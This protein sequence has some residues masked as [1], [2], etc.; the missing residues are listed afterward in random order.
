[1][2]T[3]TEALESPDAAAA[4][5]VGGNELVAN[6]LGEYVQ[7]Q[8][9]KIKGGDSGA[10][11]VIIGLILI[12]IIFQ[13]E[14]SKFLTSGNL[15]NLIQQSGI[16]VMLG[17]AEVYALLLGEIDLSTGFVA[18]IGA[19]ITGELATEP[20]NMNWALA[21]AI[22]LAA[23]AVIGLVQGL[24]ITKLGLPSFVVTLAGYL[25]FN[26]VLLY[27]IQHDKQATGGSI[28]VTSKVLNDLVYGTLSNTAGWVVTIAI[29][30]LYGAYSL[31]SHF[32]RQASGLVTP[33]LALTAIKV[34]AI[35]IG[36]IAVVLICNHNR[37][38]AGSHLSGIPWVVPIILVVFIL[39]TVL[40]NRLR[41]G[42]YLY[43]IGGNA[44]AAR[45]AGISLTR[46][47]VLAFMLC[48]FT[49]GIAGM[50]YLSSNG[51]VGADI[52]GGEYVLY[53]VAAAVIGGTSLFGGRGKMSQAVLGGIVITTIYNGMGLIQISDAGQD[54]VI[55]L[56]LLAAV[57]VDAVA[58]RG[59]TT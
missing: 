18:G 8:W 39:Y 51:G 38:L 29:V 20:H 35:A 45:R 26:G 34:T 56:V 50:V 25:G 52:P 1:M 2:S 32:R 4:P 16:F 49:A 53:A 11:P 12:V 55:A 37:G 9:K 19:V 7:A 10:L 42:R 13:V 5:L 33:P 30:A 24:I 58:R 15:V 22:G 44:E 23:C 54:M 46:I 40:L 21:I 14:N 57:T 59:R 41:F 28:A 36:G 17:M 27:L 31:V 6:S 3:D 48:S 43:A 47:K